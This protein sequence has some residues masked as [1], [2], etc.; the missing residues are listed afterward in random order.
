M[1][2]GSPED[3]ILL[4]C[5]AALSILKQVQ[6]VVPSVI[7]VACWPYPLHC[8]VQID[9]QFEGQGKQAAL[10]AL[11]SNMHWI[12]YCTVVDKDVD[13]Y[14]PRDVAWAMASRCCPDEDIYVI[15]DTPSFYGDPRR[16]H[17]GRLVMD[18]TAP[19]DRKKEYER[20]RIPGETE[21]NLKDY[22]E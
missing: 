13:I 5:S 8:I 10:A 11:G 14:S 18:A 15:P 20:K 12:K 19:F 9:Q 17:W 7:D 3:L 16:M 21:I 6:K 2:A 22:L 4:G 1:L